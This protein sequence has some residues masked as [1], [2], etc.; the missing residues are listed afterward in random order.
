MTRFDVATIGFKVA[1]ATLVKVVWKQRK[2]KKKWNGIIAMFRIV[3][4]D[5]V[6]IVLVLVAVINAVQTFVINVILLHIAVNV[7]KRLVANAKLQ[8]IV[9]SVKRV[10]V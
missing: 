8:C 5:L 3:P 9:I 10:G 6:K 4:N 1:N 2:K 7:K